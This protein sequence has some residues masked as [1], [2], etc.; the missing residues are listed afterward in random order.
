M[1]RSPAGSQ[2]GDES[3][4]GLSRTVRTIGAA[5]RN[6]LQVLERTRRFLPM[7]RALMALVGS[8]SAGAAGAA[9]APAHPAAVKTVVLGG[10]GAPGV[11][12]P[13]MP[14][15]NVP[16]IKVDTVGFPADW[17]KIVVFNLDPAGAVV[18]DAAGKV[19][20]VVDAARI[21]ERGVD[22]ASKDP[23]W[24]VDLTDLKA[25][26]R[27]TIE[28]G[29]AAPEVSDPFEVA[30]S[31]YD[32]ALIAGLKSF[33]FQRTRTTLDAPY[34]EWDGELYT[35]D[36]PSHV[37]DDVGWDLEHYPDKVKRWQLEA[38]WHDA[39]NYDMY[40]PSTAPSAQALLLAYEWAPER[41][42]DGQLTI[43]ESGNGIPDILDETRWGLTWILSMQEPGGA[44]RHREAV[45]ESS[46]ELPADRDRTVR[47]VAGPS[48]AAT[49]KAV[50]VLAMAS[51]IYA[52]HDDA[53]AARCAG[54]ARRGWTW[55]LEHP[56][57][58][59]A[60]GKGATQPL[61]DDE[62][63]GSDAGARM[64]AAAEVWRTFRDKRALALA[65][66]LL[67]DDDASPNA[68]LRGAW[69]NLGRWAMWRLATDDRTPADL[70]G[71]ARRRLLDA[72]ALV[73]E[74]V[75]QKDGYRCA[76]EP[77]DYYW[78][79][80]SNLMEKAHVLAMAHRLDPAER[81]YLDAARD[82]LHWVLGRN[83][84]G[85]S[86]VTRV[87]KGPPRLYHMEWGPR[88]PP[89]PGYL[90]GGPNGQ[91][92]AILAPD[93]PAKALLW[94]NPQPLRSGLPAHSLW[95]WRQ[96][97]LWDAGFAPEES[98]D[99]GWWAVTEPDILYSANFVLALVSVR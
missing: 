59:I 23:V 76:S 12:A 47:W 35:R 37:H 27:Y 38:G 55:L 15:H 54:A 49:A 81:W 88:E 6:M 80:N 9:C 69:A 82:Q 56:T 46:P 63:G 57:R 90:I 22:L 19:V 99:N 32:R 53:F 74:Q 43:P 36:A 41:F 31:P 44:F 66:A 18:K 8:I 94:D 52:G 87:G 26:G 67:D 21:S 85:Y 39:G 72:A 42:T 62:P 29:T 84:N 51:R 16:A 34:A 25:P 96:S 5:I 97:D 24:Q 10:D 86:M 93:A 7:G 95:H 64:V 71:A 40:V 75:E 20:I 48:T 2:R 45:M 50:A 92:M 83:P 60:D 78:A 68:I 33:Y 61:W 28:V 3:A 30:S 89:P 91:E 13:A 70:R 58:V 77:A 17:R 73:R 11:A 79:H 65:R 98:W 4:A 14:G 1:E